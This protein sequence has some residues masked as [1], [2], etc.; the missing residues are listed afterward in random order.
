[1]VDNKELPDGLEDMTDFF[2]SWLLYLPPLGISM[3]TQ[4]EVL[5]EIVTLENTKTTP[6][7]MQDVCLFEI[8]I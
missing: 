3:S 4:V 1:M 5:F 7:T 2:L 8:A 6:V